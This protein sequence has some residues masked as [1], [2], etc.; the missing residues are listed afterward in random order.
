MY[1]HFRAHVVVDLNVVKERSYVKNKPKA[2][3]TIHSWQDP[4]AQLAIRACAS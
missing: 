3:E 2:F 4:T 1:R